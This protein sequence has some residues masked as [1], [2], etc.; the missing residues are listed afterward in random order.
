MEISILLPTLGE[1]KE[2]TI[3]LFDS[4]VNQNYKNFEVVII[5][6]DNHN[7]VG[8]LIN[9]Y[10]CLN[11]NHI[12]INEKGLS[13]ARNVGIKQCK[14]NIVVLSDDDCWYP[15]DAMK[16][17][18]NY[19][20]NK[21]DI[22]L[23]KIYDKENNIDYK[24]YKKDEEYIN[25]KY[26]LMSKSS[27]EVAFRKDAVRQYFDERFGLGST[28][29]CGEEIDFLVTNFVEGSKILYTPHITVYHPRKNNSNNNNIIA[30]GALYAKHY[31]WVIG[32]GVLCRDLIKKREF[33]FK[34]FYLGYFEYN[35]LYKGKEL[36]EY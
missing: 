22:L 28:F 32:F 33:N 26:D 19:F 3:R 1:R 12:K 2:E 15:N 20:N 10:S 21:I 17:I 5:S 9:M 23:T 8:N 14:G 36:C 27:I 6:Q 13:K 35:R 25:T 29:I 30:K 18:V 11:F 24:K 16:N 34:N 7:E 4:L 31:S